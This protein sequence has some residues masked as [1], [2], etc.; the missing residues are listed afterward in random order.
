MS[1][2]ICS[3]STVHVDGTYVILLMKTKDNNQL[4]GTIYSEIA[5]LSSLVELSLGK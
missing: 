3:L 4:T 1:Q 2:N 5:L